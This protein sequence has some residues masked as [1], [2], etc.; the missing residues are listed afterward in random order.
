M[1]RPASRPASP[2]ADGQIRG[3]VAVDIAGFTRADRDKDIHLYLR[4]S[5]YDILQGALGAV[6]VAWEACYHEDRGDGVLLVLP[7]D[8]SLAAIIGPLTERLRDLIQRHNRVSREVADMQLRV[9]VHA[10]PVSH[11]GY[12]IVS[13]DVNFLYRMLDTK[14]LKHLLAS[15]G[16]ELAMIVS[17]T[18]HRDVA[19]GSPDQAGQVAFRQV[20]FQFRYAR[21][22]AWICA[23]GSPSELSRVPARQEGAHHGSVKTI[24][25]P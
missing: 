23:P 13:S 4:R 6:G 7:A 22:R 9:A 11:D 15:S 16:A 10:G 25:S 21:A 3:L 5:L 14:A 12:G 18:V 24:P 20:R 1:T 2:L 19:A 17:E 8:V